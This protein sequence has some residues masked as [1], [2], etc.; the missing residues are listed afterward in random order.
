MVIQCFFFFYLIEPQQCKH[1]EFHKGKH[2]K[3][4]S[5]GFKIIQ[6]PKNKDGAS[7]SL[8]KYYTISSL[9]CS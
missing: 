8:I 6:F 2:V 9:L 4:L 5:L 1:A 7:I 3:P